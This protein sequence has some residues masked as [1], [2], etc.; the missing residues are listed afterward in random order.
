MLQVVVIVCPANESVY[1]LSQMRVRVTMVKSSFRD[2]RR[3]CTSLTALP[4]C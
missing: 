3:L 4:I 1:I 2:F